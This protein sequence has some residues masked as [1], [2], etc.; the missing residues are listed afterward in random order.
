LFAFLI[1]IGGF[2][3]LGGFIFRTLIISLFG[4]LMMLVLSWY[5]AGCSGA[6]GYLFAALGL[7]VLI[8]VAVNIFK[9]GDS[10]FD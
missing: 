5:V 2:A 1:I 8:V 9:K 4:G 6:L 3:V 7:I 10:G